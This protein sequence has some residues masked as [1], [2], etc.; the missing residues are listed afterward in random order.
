MSRAPRLAYP[1]PSWRKSRVVCPIASVGKSAKQMEMS[2]AVMTSSTICSY[3][4][5]SNVPSSPQNFSRLS[6]ARLHEELSSDMYS[7]H[8]LEAV[9]RPCSGVVCQSLI[10]LSYCR[11][12]SNTGA[13][14]PPTRARSTCRWTTPRHVL[15]ARVG[16]GDAHVFGSGVPVVDRAVVL[17][18]G[19]GALPG[20]LGHLVEQLP[21]VD[22][23]DDAAVGARAQPEFLAGLHRAHE[24]VGHPHGVVRVLV[25]HG[26]DV[27]A[28]EVDVEARLAQ[29]ADLVFL[30]GLGFDELFDVGV[31]DVED[32]HL[33]RP[34]GGPTGFDRAGGGVGPAHEGDRARGGAAGR[35]E[36]L[37]GADPRQV[38]ARTGAA[39]EDQ[40]FF[41]VPVE[42]RI[43][44]VVDRE[45][46]ARGDLL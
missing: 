39:L 44:R 1:M 29:R 45:N 7:E 13:S 23:V 22:G 2:I 21:G 3:R 33:R 40:A 41:L 26:D 20:S 8:G 34:A 12:G 32:D 17:Q 46:E 37:R 24:L 31:V 18:A 4:V 28:A 35:E 5:M 30:A 36:F 6:E 27:F 14:P 10:V 43:H 25:L 15:R 19:V 11:P 42:D 38:E 16:G 9:M